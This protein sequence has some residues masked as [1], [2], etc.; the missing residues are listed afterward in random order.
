MSHTD[1][2]AIF[3]NRF[4]DEMLESK[5]AESVTEDNELLQSFLGSLNRRTMLSSSVYIIR[6]GTM[7]GSWR[8]RRQLSWQEC[9]R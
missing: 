6:G 4:G 2:R 5:D 1:C 3:L 8:R 7:Y 9:R